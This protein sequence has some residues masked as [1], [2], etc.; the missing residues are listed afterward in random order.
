MVRKICEPLFRLDR[1]RCPGYLDASGAYPE[2]RRLSQPVQ[3]VATE[4]AQ[5]ARSAYSSVGRAADS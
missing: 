2:A 1:A 4:R 3:R 5:T